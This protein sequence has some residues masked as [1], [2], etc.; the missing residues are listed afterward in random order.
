[1]LLHDLGDVVLGDAAIEGTVGV[2]DH[3]GA[4]RAEAEAAGLHDLDFFIQTLRLQLFSQTGPDLG[5]A[6]GGT[7]GT[8]ANQDM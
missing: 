1:M 8:S 2:D 6:G 3:N 4:E 5:A 7:A